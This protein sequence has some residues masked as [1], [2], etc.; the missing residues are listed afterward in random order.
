[1]NDKLPLK[2]IG[3]Y[4]QDGIHPNRSFP[5]AGRNKMNYTVSVLRRLNYDIDIISA[6]QVRLGENGS[7]KKVFDLSSKT[8]LFLFRNIKNVG[9]IST[10]FN[11]ILTQLQLFLF[12]L[13]NTNRQSIV[14]A[15]HSIL[16][17]RT[18]LWV[19]KI[20]RFKLVLELNEIYSDASEKFYNRRND[21]LRIIKA[22]DGY[23][24][25]N[26]LM[27]QA[28]NS[29]GKPFGVEYGIYKPEPRL[30]EP[31]KDGKIH[32]VY[33]GTLDPDKGGAQNTLIA[34]EYL[35]SNYH[36]H[37]IGFGSEKQINNIKVQIDDLLKTS[38]CMISYDGCLDGDEFIRFIQKCHIG[39][40]TQKT[41]AKFNDTS[42]PSKILTYFANGL[43]VVSVN[44][45]VIKACSLS[46][47]IS[48]FDRVEGREIANAIMAVTDFS[49]KYN[50]LKD[51]D[52]EFEE[53]LKGMLN[54]LTND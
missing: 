37:I 51:L 9:R 25:P 11:Y 22:A 42:F 47:Y 36:I 1:M 6:A 10:I 20:K 53:K 8:R 17:L 31:T 29:N 21:E 18:V 27:N 30:N 28:F 49:P 46:Q 24:F 44:I 39:L 12:L 14:I 7:K 19:K 26:D 50:I 40:S 54:S 33:A 43:Q 52:M 38:S 3:Y 5:L 2:Y 32:V 35:P 41:D 13:R 23:I 16:T 34:S 4:F 48:F 15:Y 45:P